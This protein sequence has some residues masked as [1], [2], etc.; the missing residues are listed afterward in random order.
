[1]ETQINELIELA[2]KYANLAQGNDC[3]YMDEEINIFFTD[4]GE[5]MVTFC[6]LIE[7]SIWSHNRIKTEFNIMDVS[8]IDKI[9]TIIEDLKS[10]LQSIAKSI[11]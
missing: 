7:I 6:D 4:N 2:R 5:P 11:S 1:M 8:K 10:Y 9:P 3:D